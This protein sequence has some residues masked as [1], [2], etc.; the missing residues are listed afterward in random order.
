MARLAI[1]PADTT[2]SLVIP[3]QILEVGGG[4][5]V[6][7][8]VVLSD[9]SESGDSTDPLLFIFD[10]G[11]AGF[12]A[13]VPPGSQGTF[14]T[15]TTDYGSTFNRYAS[16]LELSGT[17]NPVNVTFPNASAAQVFPV[18]ISVP[19]QAEIKSFPLLGKFYGD[20]GAGPNATTFN[21]Q[22]RFSL[23]TV[24]A[25]LGSQYGNGFIVD[26]GSEPANG[27]TGSGQLIAGL[28]DTL[29]GLFPVTI[30]MVS[31]GPY[32]PSSQSEPAQSVAT[33]SKDLTG[34]LTLHSHPALTL[35]DATFVLDT[36]TAPVLLYPGSAVTT[37]YAPSDGKP[38]TLSITSGGQTATLFSVTQVDVMGTESNQPAGFINAGLTPFFNNPIL[39]DLENGVVGFPAT[40]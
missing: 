13:H 7:I 22:N 25:Q 39:F 28:T 38:L 26:T 21:Q 19:T 11:A 30:P 35:T 12:F 9:Q 17:A 10:T 24:L 5:K 4:Y 27:K 36:G 14:E 3:L 29:R 37:N 23:L 31:E 32:P 34:T 33:F 20:F 6:W 1:P 18:I 16:T 8:S 15:P 40:S 2:S